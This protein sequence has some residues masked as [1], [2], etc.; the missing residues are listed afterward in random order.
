MI[1]PR[2]MLRECTGFQWDESNDTKNWDKHDVTCGECEQVFFNRPLIVRRDSEHAV[3]EPRYFALGI[4]DSDRLLFVV[5]T[6]RGDLI[7]V[8]SAR[9]MTK[10][11]Q[12][13]YLS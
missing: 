4:T 13:I 1:K 10:R 8:I 5:F 3:A 12:E 11:E 6:I 7:R 9:D 2:D